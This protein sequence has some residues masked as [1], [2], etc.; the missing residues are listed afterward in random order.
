MRLRYKNLNSTD[1]LYLVYLS[2][3]ERQFESR[4]DACQWLELTPLSVSRARQKLVE[5]GLVR[6]CGFRQMEGTAYELTDVGWKELRTMFQC[7]SL[8]RKESAKNAHY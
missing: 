8:T 6:E 5:N 2:N 7:L 1:R 3:R 4:E